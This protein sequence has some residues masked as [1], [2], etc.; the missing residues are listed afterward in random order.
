MAFAASQPVETRHAGAAL[1]VKGGVR[2]SYCNPAATI[3]GLKLLKPA[4]KVGQVPGFQARVDC[5]MFQVNI[6]EASC[7]SVPV[8]FGQDRVACG[9]S[10]GQ[11]SGQI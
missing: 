2:I 1:V 7:L 5:A 8:L 11:M 9:R 4:E 6:S 10:R 3:P